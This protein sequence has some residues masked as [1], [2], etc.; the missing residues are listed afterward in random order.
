MKV[1]LF[2]CYSEERVVQFGTCDLCM[3]MGSAEFRTFMFMDVE[4]GRVLSAEAQMWEYGDLVKAEE[5]DN[6][7]RFAEY[8]LTNEVP[9]YNGS[10]YGFHW[11]RE[12]IE[13]YNCWRVNNEL[14]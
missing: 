4:T 12:V 6:L 1:K 7:A 5:V 11:V 10:M 2:D 9:R 8:L 3:S 13:D 14:D